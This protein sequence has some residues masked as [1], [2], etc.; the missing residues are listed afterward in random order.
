MCSSWQLTVIL[1]SVKAVSSARACLVPL[2]SFQCSDPCVSCSDS[3]SCLSAS[4]AGA[5]V[6]GRACEEEVLPNVSAASLRSCLNTAASDQ[7]CNNTRHEE[8]AGSRPNLCE[9]SLVSMRDNWCRDSDDWTDDR[10]AHEGEEGQAG[11]YP[12][13]PATFSG[14]AAEAAATLAARADAIADKADN[15][16]GSRPAPVP[17]PM[18]SVG[19]PAPPASPSQFPSAEGLPNVEAVAPSAPPEVEPIAPARLLEPVPVEPAEMPG[20]RPV[21]EA[22]AVKPP[23]PAASPAPT[24]GALPRISQPAHDAALYACQ[25]IPAQRNVHHYCFERSSSRVAASSVGTGASTVGGPGSSGQA[26]IKE[27][28]PAGSL[29]AFASNRKLREQL[30]EV[31]NTV[32][33]AKAQVAAADDVPKA[34]V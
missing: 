24:S 32:A 26:P 8:A 9:L 14:S 27:V 13:A 7:T 16:R 2:N 25:E 11:G 6:H 33:H 21:V 29:E 23:Q 28:L 5:H 3:R 17:V 30:E 1:A 34:Q 19:A 31:R 20:A 4:S 22:S 10:E 18:G 15:M 12:R